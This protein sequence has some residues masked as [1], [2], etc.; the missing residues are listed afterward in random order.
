MEISQIKFN[1]MPACSQALFMVRT[2]LS[3][4]GSSPEKTHCVSVAG[5]T[6]P[7][8]GLMMKLG[9]IIFTLSRGVP[10]QFTLLLLPEGKEVEL[11]MN[12]KR[13]SRINGLRSRLDLSGGK[14][15]SSFL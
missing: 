12:G 1:F 3:L 8:S 13:C 10:V 2:N 11:F 7:W 5:R 15:F 6:E 9:P 4:G 14:S